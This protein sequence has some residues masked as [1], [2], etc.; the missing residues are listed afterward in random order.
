M[1]A[2][3]AEGLIRPRDSLERLLAGRPTVADAGLMVVAAYAVQRMAVILLAPEEEGAGL[4][5][6]LVSLSLA[7]AFTFMIGFLI[8]R[9]GRAF[10]GKATIEQSLVTA[11]WHALV[12]SLLS[13]LIVLGM[14]GAE[15]G[16]TAEDVSPAVFLSLALYLAAGVWLLARFTATVHGF[17]NEWA[18]V[19]VILAVSV[20]LSSLLM[21][22]AG[23]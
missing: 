8:Y 9:I 2:H 15:L 11:G 19:G 4:F 23:G 18:V 3:I 16:A 13:P 12:M 1:L 17:R 20:L 7:V 10:G 6:H 14:A 21:A 22:L 5:V